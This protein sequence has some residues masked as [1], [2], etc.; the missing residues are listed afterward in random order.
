MTGEVLPPQLIYQGKTSQCLPS[1]EF[2]DDWHI[3]Y[4]INHWSNEGTMKEYLEH[5]LPPY[6][7]GKKN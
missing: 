6:N 2:P 5:I 7:D 1:V 4:S 3:T